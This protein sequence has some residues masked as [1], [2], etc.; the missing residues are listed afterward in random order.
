MRKTEF[1]KTAKYVN[2]WICTSLLLNQLCK[3]GVLKVWPGGQNAALQPIVSWP[4][5]FFELPPEMVTAGL[6]NNHFM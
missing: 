1:Y 6:V 4:T 2:E 3:P 5:G